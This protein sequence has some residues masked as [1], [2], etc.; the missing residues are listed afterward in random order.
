MTSATTKP[1]YESWSE[2]DRVILMVCQGAMG[3]LARS[4]PGKDFTVITS[5]VLTSAE[6]C[7]QSPPE[8]REHTAVMFEKL[9]KAIRAEVPIIMGM[10]TKENKYDA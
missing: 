3:A 6:L 4:F 5:L 8:W 1:T 2:A 9:A 10:P 7:R